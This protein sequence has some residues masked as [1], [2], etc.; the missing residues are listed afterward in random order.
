MLC[1][2]VKLWDDP[3][4]FGF[5]VPDGGGADVFVHFREIHGTPRGERRS[6]RRGL[7][8]EYEIY[9]D[10]RGTKATNVKLL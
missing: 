6:L 2:T 3:K 5:I 10:D 4:G 9:Q 1:G 7:R 8:V